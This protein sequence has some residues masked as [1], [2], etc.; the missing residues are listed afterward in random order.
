M[1][2][3]PLLSLIHFPVRV[4]QASLVHISKV[5]HVTRQVDAEKL[6]FL[7]QLNVEAAN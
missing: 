2:S 5:I 7:S 6:S 1:F 4:P 3:D